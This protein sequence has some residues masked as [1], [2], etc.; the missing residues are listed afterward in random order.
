MTQRVSLLLCNNFHKEAETLFTREPYAD[1][2]LSFYPSNCGNPPLTLEA[3]EHYTSTTDPNSVTVVVGSSCI[4]NLESDAGGRKT[5]YNH[6][7]NCFHMIVAPHIV[8]QYLKERAYFTTSGW[9]EEWEHHVKKEWK[10]TREIAQEFF[11]EIA[12]K[13]V[14]LDTGIS[15]DAS[16]N[17]YEFGTFVN[18]PTESYYVGLDYFHLYLQHL[19]TEGRVT[20]LKRSLREGQKDASDRMVALDLLGNLSA[21][22]EEEQVI[23]KILEFF[24]ILFSAKLIVYLPITEGT[25]GKLKYIGSPPKDETAFIKELLAYENPIEKEDNGFCLHISS[26][27]KRLGI[28]KVNEV[29]FPQYMDKYLNLAL[30]VSAVCGLA[31]EN[32]RR[33][34]LLRSSEEQQGLIISILQLFIKSNDERDE[35]REILQLLREYTG[36]EAIAIRLKSGEDFPYH[37]A[38]GFPQEFLKSETSLCIYDE[39]QSLQYDN[40]GR[41][42]L[43]CICGKVI[44]NEEL[45]TPSGYSEYGS[46]WT[47]NSQSLAAHLEESKN[48]PLRGRCIMEEYESI[49]LIPLRIGSE[50]FG[51]LQLNDH[52]SEMFTSQVISFLEHVGSSISIALQRKQ[53][54][55]SLR[56]TQQAL[57]QRNRELRQHRDNLEEMVGD[58][59]LELKLRN[60]ELQKE[61]EQRRSVEKSLTESNERYELAQRV[62][63]MGSWDWNIL[64]GDLEWSEQTE[65]IFGFGHGEFAKSY[66]AF[67]NC[68]PTKKERQAVQRALDNALNKGSEYN[69]EHR[70]KLQ[71]GKY[72]WVSEVG[73]I[74]RDSRGIPIRMIGVVQDI[75]EKKEMKGLIKR[76]RDFEH[77][78]QEIS[79]TFISV[80]IDD[81]DRE[82]EM[83]LKECATFFDVDVVTLATLSEVDKKLRL[84]HSSDSKESSYSEIKT[85]QIPWI[86]S[87]L[88]NREI[89]AIHSCREMP[90]DAYPDQKFL[91][92]SGIQATLFV[93]TV[94]RN[95]IS[96]FLNLSSKSKERE[97][98]SNEL[99]LLQITA[100]IFSNALERKRSE[101][102]L[103][104]HQ[105]HL[106]DIVDERTEELIKAVEAAEQANFAKSEFLANMSHEIRTPMNA[107]LGFT[108]VLRAEET[109]AEKC[110]YLDTIYSSGE[111]L[112]TLINDI[113]DLSKIES[114]K[115]ELQYSAVSLKKLFIELKDIFSQ[116]CKDKKLEFI[117]TGKDLEMP[118]IIIDKIRLR[119]ILI[120]LIGNAI[121][122]TDEGS[123]TLSLDMKEENEHQSSV[124]LSIAVTDTG[125]GISPD[126]QEVIFEAFTQMKGQKTATFGG[127]GLGL[128][129]TL[130]LVKMMNGEL[131]LHSEPGKGS[132]FEMTFSGVEFAPNEEEEA[133]H[134]RAAEL[135]IEFSP[136][137]ILIADDIDY[138]RELI[139][140][141]LKGFNFTLVTAA[142]GVE[143][144]QQSLKEKPDLILL[145]MKMPGMSGYDTARALSE[146]TVLRTIPVI[147]VTASALK[148]D[149]KII[150]TICDGYLRKPISRTLLLKEMMRFLPYSE[151]ESIP[152]KSGTLFQS[153][154]NRLLLTSRDSKG[155]Q[156]MIKCLI[157]DDH[158][159]NRDLLKHYLKKANVIL[160]EA[161]NG[162][163]ALDISQSEKPHIILMDMQMPI[164][165]GYD[166]SKQIKENPELKN[167]YII[168]LSAADS[169]SEHETIRNYCDAF[170]SKPVNLAQISQTILTQFPNFELHTKKSDTH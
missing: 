67:L 35:I 60:K 71:N 28:I 123:I 43:Y 20:Y 142:D 86:M 156:E 104:I 151:A 30:S 31:I 49:A 83:A 15:A 125:I 108:D 65:E 73:D 139:A 42:S 99:N 23:S 153:D 168:A 169:L 89:I 112:L 14:L 68:I 79:L 135:P 33:Y 118:P 57:E 17:L 81:I 132:A 103:R 149:E 164:L 121:K 148:E 40:K 5:L 134:D 21:C 146:D 64:T 45:L 76:Q 100:Q 140:H 133:I 105:H 77:L 56:Q 154:E 69:I 127:T 80:E 167:T 11:A 113:L 170:L 18:L 82:M 48:H 25:A 107:V 74:T 160:Y 62:V 13:I 36:I 124:D 37:C 10:F 158:A 52:R 58:K 50:T 126:Q 70:I 138:N 119:Q 116:K 84:T 145:D 39:N 101:N 75:T 155:E 44:R 109:D 34:Q 91:V 114:G 53:S 87:K 141:F 165:D 157:V 120:N 95:N 117:I 92:E 122:F 128:A 93:P 163:E 27:G 3:L 85:S 41:P 6:L 131:T 12:E 97:W 24:V 54:L 1:V 98:S 61:V 72:R 9:L 59:T 143:V 150:S 147:A 8:A 159:E 47:N 152:E 63:K 96:G 66:K 162:L 19:I 144:L 110:H 55:E 38:I 4:R 88:R 51:L 22:S 161:A 129:I 115:M 136:A 130:R 7:D 90:F 46:F 111:A 94:Y 78:L 137:T 102:Q 32:S 26:N 106:E 29:Q 16:K 166:A 2:S